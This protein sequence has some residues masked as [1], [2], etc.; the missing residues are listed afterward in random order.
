MI[1]GLPST[2]DALAQAQSAQA[3][4][5]HA[6]KTDQAARQFEGLLMSMVLQTMR[7]TVQ[8]SGLFGDSG[9]SR[10]TYEYLMDRAVV[11]RAVSAGRGWGLADKLKASWSR[12]GDL[13]AKKELSAD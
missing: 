6:E 2:V 10:S 11:D 12:F 7:K 13:D 4:P 3:M 1:P 8:P 9:S 5:D